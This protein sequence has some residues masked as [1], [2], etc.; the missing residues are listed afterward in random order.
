MNNLRT[1]LSRFTKYCLWLIILLVPILLEGCQVYRASES[2]PEYSYLNPSM[3][4]ATVGR[5]TIIELANN[6]AYPK[7]AA[8][9]TEALFLALQKKQVFGLT[10]VY[11]DDPVFQSLKIEPDAA[12]YTLEQ[13]YAMSKVLKCH[14]VLVGT[15]TQYK[16]YPHMAIG[17]RLR[18]L[19]LNNGQLLWA[20]EQVWDST[21]KATKSRIKNHFR[22]Q[23]L[24]GVESLREQVT[25][26]SQLE[27][28][29]FVTYEIA[30][31]L[32]PKR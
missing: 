2:V 6:S 10:K 27:F 16:P 28:V 5:V 31:T 25:V 1:I 20:V 17:L 24:S 14:A 19:D 11:Q 4:I 30:E 13:L 22:G 29:R 18:L 8:D 23:A 26:I 7:I 12:Y 9:V 32:K 3:D 15:I 21:D